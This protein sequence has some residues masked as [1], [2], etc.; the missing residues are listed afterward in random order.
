MWEAWLMTPAEYSQM[1]TH[2]FISPVQHGITLVVKK[3]PV[4]PLTQ[5]VVKTPRLFILLSL[6]SDVMPSF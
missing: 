4:F 5:A 1:V 3:R 6:N 2:P